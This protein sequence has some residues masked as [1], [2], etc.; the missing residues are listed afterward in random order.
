MKSFESFLSTATV[1]SLFC[2]A[3]ISQ[4]GSLKSFPLSSVRL[5]ESPFQVAQQRDMEYML[6]LDPDRLLAPYLIDAGIE[7]E[8]ER[9]GNWESIGLDGHT[10][11]HYLSALSLMYAATGNE[12]LSERLDYMLEGI[13]RCQEKNGNGYVSGIPGGKTLFKEIAE[14][15]TEA[16]SFSLANR[17][18]P[19]YNIHKLFAGLRDA[20]LV[21][22]KEKARDMLVK[23][24]DWFFNISGNF[25]DEQ[26]QLILSTEHGGLNEVFADVYDITGDKKYLTLAE[27][28][29][30]RF[31]LD[32]LIDGE[33]KLTGLHANTQIPKVIG[34]KRIA[35]LS[36]KK[37]WDAAA[38]FFW[39]LI[40]DKWTISI[41][42]NSV[43]E[44][45]HPVDDYSTMIESNQGPETCNTYNMLRLTKLL[46]LS[47]PQG[48]YMDYY[49]RALY[50][51]I[52]STE[53]PEKGGFVYFTPMRPRH[54]RV[55]SQPQKCFWCC[56]G[57]GLENH[58]KYGEMI[59]AHDDR[60]LYV[61]LFIPSTL[62]WKEKGLILTQQTQF[63]Y[64]ES[65]TLKLQLDS[66]QEFSLNIR[67]PG[68]V[69]PGEMK[70]KINDREVQVSNLKGPYVRLERMWTSGDMVT[71]CLPMH[72]KLEYLPDQSSW[73][74]IIH[75]PI[76]LAAVTDTTDLKGLFADDSR[77]GHVAS[78]LLYP[79]DK[80]PV[81]VSEDRDFTGH[82]KPVAEKPLTFTLSGLIYPKEQSDLE[83]VPFFTIHEA[84]YMVYWPVITPDSLE[85]RNIAMQEKEKERLALEALTLDQ[86]ATGEQQP[87][88]EHNFK[89]EDTE[90]GIYEGRHW[91]HARG[92]FSYD[93]KNTNREG[94]IL[95]VTYS[96][97]D[98]GRS[99]D[100]MLNNMLLLTV[101]S[102]ESKGNR[103]FDVDYPI[104][105]AILDS[106]Q[107]DVL[108]VKFIAREGSVA[109]GVYYI[110]LLR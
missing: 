38:V 91:R 10:A 87:E 32:P 85:K 37:D 108:N 27:R 68:W 90:S 96:G 44:H 50:N 84:R 55:Y 70:I 30:H 58:G 94:R 64:S 8:A 18:V 6:S 93:L 107:N 31:I 100:I 5:L 24:T 82:I 33:N 45:F 59:Y 29:S 63:P 15:K 80:A 76:V 77:M 16:G 43:R 62:K 109:G 19:L 23:L 79:I 106:L 4:E 61:N 66:P 7:P 21:A 54:Y 88:V 72:T 65:T 74:S 104:P 39:N 17:W 13:S 3:G 9:Y 48:K 67:Y 103:F 71:I 25:T 57:T 42:G 22:G 81:I 60:N 52:L 34:F 2:M 35:D 110:R 98:Q 14:G 78:G 105:Q 95:R 49:E 86:V 46:F 89:G 11:G 40:R 73:A 12:A 51:H 36:G 41:G 26:I 101:K 1:I 97:W 69:K 20:Y 47:D 75:G 92:W 102:D 28:Y 83:L 53:H 56:V 99:F